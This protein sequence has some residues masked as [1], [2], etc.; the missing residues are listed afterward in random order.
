MFVVCSPLVCIP[1]F[2]YILIVGPS[3]IMI[4][5]LIHICTVLNPYQVCDCNWGPQ[6]TRTIQIIKLRFSFSSAQGKV[7]MLRNAGF[8]LKSWEIK[9]FYPFGAVVQHQGIKYKIICTLFS[10][11][12]G[13][14]QNQTKGLLLIWWWALPVYVKGIAYPLSNSCG[15]A[16]WSKLDCP[17]SFVQTDFKRSL[18]LL[19]YFYFISEEVKVHTPGIFIL[20]VLCKC[21]ALFVWSPGLFAYY[22]EITW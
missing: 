17:G 13:T 18:K 19:L 15:S 7:V 14:E 9:S 2:I 6:A 20:L 4:I 11:W 12:W 21:V 8:H 10:H 3:K 16:V 1:L 5:F 22:Y